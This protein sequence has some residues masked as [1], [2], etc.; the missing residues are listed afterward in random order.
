MWTKQLSF[1][2]DRSSWPRGRRV[3]LSLIRVNQLT[4]VDLREVLIHI[5]VR[6]RPP[7]YSG[8][9]I[10]DFWAWLRYGQAFDPGLPLKIAQSWL[11]LDP[12]Q[13]TILS[14]DLGVGMASAILSPSMNLVAMVDTTF[15]VKNF[16]ALFSLG[17]NTRKVGEKKTPDFLALDSS[18]KV[19]VI[20]CKG[21]QTSSAVLA[22]QLRDGEPQKE[23][24][25]PLPP[26]MR[27]ERLVAGIFVPNFRSTETAEFVVIDPPSSGKIGLMKEKEADF[28]SILI[29]SEF[30]QAFR[31]IGHLSLA[32]A[33]LHKNTIA[34]EE[35][36][37]LTGDDLAIGRGR[38]GL[39]QT[40]QVVVEATKGEIV[41]KSIKIE[42]S[43]SEKFIV[44]VISLLK[45]MAELDA[46]LIDAVLNQD[47]RVENSPN[48]SL[49]TVEFC[50]GLKCSLDFDMPK[51]LHQKKAER[52]G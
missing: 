47:Y 13:K 15:L 51:V 33:V 17:A 27:G 8:L 43:M 6:T 26:T 1:T 12:H 7:S 2:V 25:R 14:D 16:P 28:I 49:T 29:R 34:K 22:G 18:G 3:P 31:T 38:T 52:R 24:I 36:I 30:A 40:V 42:F 48:S 11:D 46:F 4:A 9:H 10:N 41:Q 45:S 44:Q 39:R 32:N 21:T 19:H 37:A 35:L 23:N 50:T 20:E 5:G